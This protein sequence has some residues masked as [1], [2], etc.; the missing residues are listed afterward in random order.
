MHDKSALEA[1]Y[2]L[3]GSAG[4]AVKVKVKQETYAQPRGCY[5]NV[6]HKM[7]Q[8]GGNICY[9]WL[10]LSDSFVLTAH[11]HAVWQDDRAN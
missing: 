2:A 5:A 7:V 3:I 10:I 9:G 8:C 6:A 4:P 1:F 11:H